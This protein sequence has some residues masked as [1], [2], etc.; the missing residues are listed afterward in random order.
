M[1]EMNRWSLLSKTDQKNLLDRADSILKWGMRLSS[2][3][4][5]SESTRVFNNRLA[6]GLS[7]SNVHLL[8]RIDK[9]ILKNLDILKGEGIDRPL[10]P[11]YVAVWSR[12]MLLADINLQQELAVTLVM[13]R[14][15]ETALLS[16]FFKNHQDDSSLRF[17]LVQ[18]G[19][20][21]Q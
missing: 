3:V 19:I 15:Q 18:R 13:L 8:D 7:A 9:V 21:K 11:L 1:D 4:K 10:I 17:I 2:Q 14:I 16:S 5:E 6:S 12:S 20:I